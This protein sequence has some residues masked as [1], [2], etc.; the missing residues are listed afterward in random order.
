MTTGFLV[1]LLLRPKT[2]SSRSKDSSEHFESVAAV[3]VTVPEDTSQSQ[4]FPLISQLQDY[5][6]EFEKILLGSGGIDPEG[7]CSKGGAG[8]V[9]L[10]GADRPCERAIIYRVA[11]IYA[12]NKL[13]PIPPPEESASD[14][15]QPENDD[16]CGRGPPRILISPSV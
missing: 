10:V 5:A 12:G 11:K 13:P 4:T 7:V 15:F 1:R 2:K 3:E 8:F 14:D 9:H 16:E 6:S